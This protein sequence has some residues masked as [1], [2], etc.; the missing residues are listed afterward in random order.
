MSQ[1][2]EDPLFGSYS[3]RTSCM[4][5]S[6]SKVTW[7]PPQLDEMTSFGQSET[8]QGNHSLY[9]GKVQQLARAVASVPSQE[10][11]LSGS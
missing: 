5:L 8:A 1:C 4:R 11:H 6:H 3:H 7:K 2:I 10:A 9:K